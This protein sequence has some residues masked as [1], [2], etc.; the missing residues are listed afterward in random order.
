M[1]AKYIFVA[2]NEIGGGCTPQVEVW[3]TSGFLYVEK[4][5]LTA[6]EKKI[7]KGLKNHVA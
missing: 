1:R 2:K 7:S 3:F 6:F 4:G 5:F